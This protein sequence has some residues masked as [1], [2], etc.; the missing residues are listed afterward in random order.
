MQGQGETDR[1]AG[2][3]PGSAPPLLSEDYPSTS[4]RAALA[5]D[6]LPTVLRL[7]DR[8]LIGFICFL[9]FVV[10]VQGATHESGSGCVRRR[11]AIRFAAFSLGVIGPPD[12]YVGGVLALFRRV[13]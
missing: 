2:R 10:A 9:V 4:N 1:S 12:V 8:V 11:R 13:K 5:L 6:W 3:F 7:Q